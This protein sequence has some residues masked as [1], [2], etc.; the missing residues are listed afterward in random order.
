MKRLT[1]LLALALAVASCTDLVVDE[2]FTGNQGNP[3]I[4]SGTLSATIDGVPFTS[5]AVIMTQNNQVIKFT[6]TMDA[7][8][9][10]ARTL[11]LQLAKTGD[12]NQGLGSL[13]PGAYGMLSF[14]T[15]SVLWTTLTTGPI[16]VAR[17][18]AL[19]SQRATGTFSFQAR[20]AL[21]STSPATRQVVNGVF[22]LN[23]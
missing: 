2:P 8:T 18:T 12:T 15:E 21:G 14:G 17:L 20:A 16:G 6:A 4:A 13:G 1:T 9:A 10:N 22:D 23:Y 5:S 19:N 3:L 7:G 11:V